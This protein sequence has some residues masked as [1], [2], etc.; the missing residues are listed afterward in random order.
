MANSFQEEREAPEFETVSELAENLVYRL[1]GCTDLMVRKAI[2]DVYREFC[3]ETKCLTAERVIDLEPDRRDY[4]LFPMF[5]GVIEGVRSVAVGPNLLRL[6][7]DYQA[8]GERPVVVVLSPCWL[9]PKGVAAEE[10]AADGMRM[11][12]SIAE[13][14]GTVPP[15]EA[16]RMRVV[17]EEVP[18]IGSEK[19]PPGFVASH[20]EAICSGVM[21]RLCSMT[22]RAWTDAQVAAQE[23]VRYENAKSE[24]RMRRETPPGGRFI[25]T[26]MVL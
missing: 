7:V 8:H 21:A 6:G 17:Q 12:W 26:S 14:S 20:G 1:P 19:A 22:G 11:P 5:G 25:D 24:A 18:S 9:P 10:D 4:P 13:R 2:Q 15:V 16:R 23:M 3:R